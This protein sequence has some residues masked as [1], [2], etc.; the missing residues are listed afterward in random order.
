LKPIDDQKP[1]SGLLIGSEP[2]E[3]V[4]HRATASDDK[5]DDD[6]TDTGDKKDSDTTDK[7]D[8]GDD[9]RDSDGRD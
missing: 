8:R 4:R 6:S 5:R 9:R 1:G 3:T 2:I 7:G